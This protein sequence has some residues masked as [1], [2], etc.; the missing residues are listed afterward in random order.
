MK[1][2][3]VRILVV[4]DYEPWRRFVRLA[5]QEGSLLQVIG[6]ASDGPQAVQLAQELQPNLILLDIGLPTLN[7]I[8]AARRIREVAPHSKILFLSENHF[9]DVAEE[10]LRA[11]ALGYVVKV[12]TANELLPAVQAVLQGERFISA[13]LGRPKAHTKSRHEV[14]FYPD[15]A[16]LVDGFAGI[17][18]DV[19]ESGNEVAFF[20]TKLH[21]ASLL[22][23]FRSD[24]VDI[25]APIERG[26]YNFSEVAEAL[27]QIMGSDDMP[28]R[29]RCTQAFNDLILTAAKNGRRVALFGELAPILLA[30][31]KLEAAIQLEHLTA[32]FLRTHDMDVFCGYLSGGFADAESGPVFHR[33]CAEHLVVRGR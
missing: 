6:E 17:M 15:E 13:S 26:S 8:E 10:G 23:R 28:D 25:D 12:D 20:G 19:M 29:D 7:G 3:T 4:D 2:A 30:A 32:E 11:G 1:P 18:E 14:E 21:H 9:W 33:L 22:E 31:G 24:G 16:S 5:L 27:L